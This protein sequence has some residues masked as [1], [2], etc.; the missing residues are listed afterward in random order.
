MYAISWEHLLSLRLKI[1]TMRFP[2]WSKMTI[3]V[4]T[5]HR[6]NFVLLN[7]YLPFSNT[8]L[9]FCNSNYLFSEDIAEYVACLYF[10]PT[11]Q[12]LEGCYL[13]IPVIISFKV[14]QPNLF[15]LSS[16]DVIFRTQTTLRTPV[17]PLVSLSTW[18]LEE[19]IRKDWGLSMSA[20]D[21]PIAKR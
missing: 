2:K 11:F 17:Q 13:L 14:K 20:R 6:R 3:S 16:Y 21:L 10:A 7:N 18:F 8:H 19:C 12:A 4:K 9:P 1:Q 5:F 15:N